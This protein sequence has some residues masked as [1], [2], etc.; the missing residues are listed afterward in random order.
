[1]YFN[2]SNADDLFVQCVIKWY[3]VFQDMAPQKI[4]NES[5]KYKSC[6]DYLPITEGMNF[7]QGISIPEKKHTSK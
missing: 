5:F 1:M 3:I 4:T 2:V 6:C 7:E